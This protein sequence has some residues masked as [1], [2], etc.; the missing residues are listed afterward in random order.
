MPVMA[1]SA[2]LVM[3]R[4][5]A[6]PSC[7]SRPERYAEHAEIDESQLPEDAPQG[8]VA[9]VRVRYNGTHTNPLVSFRYDGMPFQ[10]T[11]TAAGSRRAAEVIARAC[12]LRFEQGQHKEAVLRYRNDCYA[13]VHSGSSPAAKRSR[14]D[15]QAITNTAV[16]AAQQA[17]TNA[18]ATGQDASVVLVAAVHQEVS[19]NTAA[20]AQ[21]EQQSRINVGGM[22]QASMTGACI[23]Q[24]ASIDTGALDEYAAALRE[25]VSINATASQPTIEEEVATS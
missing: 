12:W 9:H 6:K 3:P 4:K 24:Q 18:A 8:H 16:G 13:R 21:Q 14:I 23:P 1:L 2:Q 22:D 25:P 7:P 15:E 20:T 11:V 19:T 17:I 10:T 5:V